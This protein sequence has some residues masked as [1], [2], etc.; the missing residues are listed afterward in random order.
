MPEKNPQRK[1]P[2]RRPGGPGRPRASQADGDLSERILDVAEEQFAKHGFDGVTTRSVA[3]LAGTTS[4]MI[5]YYFNSKRALFDAAV[6]R[7]ANIVNRERLAALDAYEAEAGEDVTV[8]GAIS[9]FLRPVM[10]K[11][12]HGGPGWRNYLALIAWVGNMQ[13]WGGEVMTRSFDP[14][15]KRLV[16]VVGKALP[17]AREQDIYWAYHF[18][19]GA[20]I[21]T[22]SGTDR[23]GRLSGGLCESSDI[24]TLEPLMVE[25]TAA[26]F[27]RICAERANR[28]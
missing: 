16:E 14:V 25:F 6:D 4:A 13:E 18:L 24:S 19:S 15:V 10:D 2:A 1:S 23:L 7:R 3:R 28:P 22:A 21:L 26:G 9:A 5:H 11:L 17:D 27:R 8:E 12:E 20:L